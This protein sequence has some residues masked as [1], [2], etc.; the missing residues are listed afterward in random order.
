MTDFDPGATQELPA[1]AKIELIE[2]SKAEAPAPPKPPRQ[3]AR[4][5]FPKLPALTEKEL[6][7]LAPQERAAYLADKQHQDLWGHLP[8]QVGQHLRGVLQ[9]A[10]NAVEN[11]AKRADTDP[12][13]FAAARAYHKWAM[14]QEM[15]AE[16]YD[17]A[18]EKVLSEGHGY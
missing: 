17:A 2:Q 13:H 12:V 5:R 8:P 14:G 15:S 6:L 9:L 11:H 18:I 7:T 3:F 4:T 1:E 16:D 10:P